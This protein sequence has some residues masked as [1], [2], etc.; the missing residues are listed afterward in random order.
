M[1]LSG[2][3]S[4]LFME[5]IRIVKEQ[6]KKYGMPKY[7]VWEN[8]K[9]ALSSNDGEDFR[10]VLEEIAKISDSNAIIPRPESKWSRCGTILGEGYSISWRLHDAQYFGVAQRRERICV[11]ADFDGYTAPQLLFESELRSETPEPDKEQTVGY[12]GNESRSQVQS[13]SKGMS[14]NIEQGREEGQGITSDTERGA[15]ETGKCLNSWDVQSKHIQPEN[16]IAEALYSGECRYGGG[17]SYVLQGQSIAIDVYNQTID[18]DVAASLTA[19][20][21]GTNTSGAKVLSFLE[22]DKDNNGQPIV[23]EP[24]TMSRVGGHVYESIAGTVRANAGDNQQAVVYGICSDGS[25]SMKSDNPHSGIYEADT[26]RTLD[27]NGGN[28]ACNQGGMMVVQKQGDD[29]VPKIICIEGNGSRDSHKGDGYRESETMYTLNT[30][31]QHA[32]CC[33]VDNNCKVYDWYRC[34]TKATDLQDTCCTINASWG[35]G[36]NNVPMV[37]KASSEEENIKY[38]TMQ[39][40]GE[41]ADCGVASSLKERDYKDATDLVV[42]GINGEVAGTLDASYYKGYGER[43]GVEREVV[44]TQSVIRRLTPRECC[45]LQGFPADWLDI[46]D[47]T[48]EKGKKHKDSDSA[49]YRAAGNSIALPFWQWLANRIVSQYEGK[50][51]TIGSLF[52]GI[53][54]FPLVFSRAGARPVWSSEIEPFCIAV[55]EKHFGKE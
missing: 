14:G 4:G 35:T 30:V 17:E 10:V 6:R 55:A 24:G 50:E 9:G 45:L 2:E 34:D 18:G 42:Q 1:G 46:G 52:D 53:S 39:R 25:N 40:I 20:C 49:K 54:G 48:D 36:G 3:R 22:R 23:F 13:V 5:Q 31:E 44:G 32:V 29:S 15:V 38:M 8:V 7:M 19:A 26:S 43:S 11:L 51:V 37:V 27:M 41:Y 33:E 47:W 12:I 21:G 16:G 28:P